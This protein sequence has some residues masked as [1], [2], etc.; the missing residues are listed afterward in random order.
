MTKLKI[1]SLYGHDKEDVQRENLSG[2]LEP[3]TF[4]FATLPP[5]ESDEELH[6]A[7]SDANVMLCLS[8]WPH[9]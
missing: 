1:F 9:S 4:E 2:K 3:G 8:R 5:T 6:R 7:V